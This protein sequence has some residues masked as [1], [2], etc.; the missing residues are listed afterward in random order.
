MH[1][2]PQRQDAG[3]GLTFDSG[4]RWSQKL[5]TCA[6][7]VKASIKTVTFNYNGTDGLKS[8]AVTDITEKSYADGDSLPLWGVEN[9]GNSYKEKE[10]S[11]IWGLVSSKYEN[12]PNV[13][14]VRQPSLYLPGYNSGGLGSEMSSLGSQNLPSSDFYSGAAS[15]AYAVGSSFSSAAVDYSGAVNMAMWARWQNLTSSPDT[16]ALIPN[17]IWTDNAAS[18]VVGT[19]GVLGPGNAA[20]HNVVPLAVTPTTTRIK[21]HWLFAIPA[22]LVVLLLIV[23]TLFA[24][25]AV[26]FRGARIGRMRRHLQQTSPGRIFTTFLYP[27]H[28]AMSLRSK[29]WNRQLGNKVIDFSGASPVATEAPMGM[30][31]E[32]GA[33]ITDA[34]HQRPGSDDDSATGERY[35]GGHS[36]GHAREAS[37]G[38]I[39]GHG[40]AT[41]QP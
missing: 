24:L 22:F 27:E 37:Q 31:S 25:L 9:T 41:P 39:G 4:S 7:A 6:T 15:T 30:P 13:S 2:V 20:Q 1:G 23:I 32:K 18:A 5:Y 12:H 3:D 40:F 29:D 21:Y 36:S 10:I 35:L 11:L 16:A 14:T 19:K 28:G 17:L 26:C 38:D 34:E 8:L 33:N